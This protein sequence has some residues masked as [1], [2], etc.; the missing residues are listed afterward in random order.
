MENDW[1][2]TM[3][4]YDKRLA[5]GKFMCKHRSGKPEC[6]RLTRGGSYNL[7]FRNEYFDGSSLAMKVPRKCKCV[8]LHYF[9][10]LPS[11]WPE[12]YRI[13]TDSNPFA[14]EKMRFEAETM[15]Y[16]A[17]RTTIPVPSVYRYGTAAENPT[18]LGPPSSS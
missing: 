1:V 7:V 16:V 11:F 2:A 6:I 4:T 10:Y 17:A 18:G 13:Q 12:T 3:A 5:I 8:F 14:E 9:I 15:I